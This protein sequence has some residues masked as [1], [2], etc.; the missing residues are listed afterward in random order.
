M[1]SAKNKYKY[2]S[3]AIKHKEQTLKLN[4]FQKNGGIIDWHSKRKIIINIFFF[5][6]LRMYIFTFKI[7]AAYIINS[8]ER[9]SLTMG[10]VN[11]TLFCHKNAKEFIKTCKRK[12][13]K[14]ANAIY[15]IKCN[16]NSVKKVK[17]QKS[18]SLLLLLFCRDAV[19][20]VAEVD[21]HDDDLLLRLL[22]ALNKAV[23]RAKSNDKGKAISFTNSPFACS[24]I[25]S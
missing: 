20:G 9:W 16:R 24:P 3:T 1:I 14:K 7:N 25:R 23:T 2:K 22:L 12:H 21:V 13:I 19:N 4:E 11:S 5:F 18:S 10:N 15:E 8:N 17:W 6:L